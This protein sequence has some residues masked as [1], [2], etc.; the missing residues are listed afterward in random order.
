VPTQDSP[1]TV[2]G[3]ILGTMQYM[4]PE[5]IEGHEADGRTD[6][7]AFGAVVYEMATGTKAFEG[8]SQASLIGAILKD[9]PRPIS[10]LQPMS[11]PALDRVIR[12][13]LAKDPDAR[14]QSA[15]DLRDELQWTVEARSQ[16]A[17]PTPKTSSPQQTN[18]RRAMPWVAGMLL[19]GAV[20]GLDVWSLTTEE[21]TN[22][23]L[24]SRFVI[25]PP[26][27]APLTQ[28][29]GRNVMISPDGRRIVYVGEDAKRGRLL[30]VRD[31][32]ALEGRAVPGTERA[33]DP[34]FSPDGAWIGFERG[35]ALM[36]VAASG[37]PPLEIVDAGAQILGS[38]WGVDD[39]VIFARDD[40]LYRVSAGGGGSVE[41]L[42]PEAEA[43]QSQVYMAPY[44][45]PGGKAVVFYLRNGADWASDRLG[46]LSLETGEQRILIG[47]GGPLYASSGHLVFVRGTTLMAAPFDLERLEV[48]GNPVALLEGI[49]RTG[50]STAQY[51]LSENGT[52]VYR[53]GTGAAGGRTLAWARRNGGEE[54]LAMEPRDYFYSRVSPDGGRVA[55]YA[56]FD[57]WIYDLARGTTTRLTFD[58]AVDVEPLWT[59][60]G[61]RV[62]FA[63]N[64]SGTYDLYW[65]RA[66]G[67]GPEE[68]L[69]MGTQHEFPGS[70]AAGGR[71]LVFMECRTSNG[72]PCDLSVLSLEGERT[73]KVLLQ[74]E[75]DESLPTVSPDGRW[76]AY[77]SNESGSSEI[78]VR[79]LPNVQ[80]GRWQVSSGGGTDPL[81]GP[82]G[83]ELFYRTATSLMVVPVQTGATPMFGNAATLF[84]LGRYFAG[85]GRD[86]D[87]APKG[88]RFILTAPV[89]PKGGAADQIVVVENFFEELKRLVPPN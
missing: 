39:T 37:G 88:D 7:F 44:V 40:G 24:I 77:Q 9:D 75:F 38:T 78:Y 76:L 42:T 29:G 6:I 16:V 28:L 46:V 2:P 36:K 45:L 50:A 82:K 59:P 58:P 80:G 3:T 20:I 83:D 70:W 19:S 65:R 49:T 17:V 51:W 73:A 12:K 55:V 1:I 86:Y 26:E 63:S 23:P 60:D 33:T 85:A 32:D 5:Q 47:G 10:S 22:R 35:T 11:P 41:R 69:T 18:W 15:R 31:I 64:R 61:E 34:F 27:S 68:R 54:A 43:G 4:A 79:P 52:L 89:A 25:T 8:N 56:A 57:I 14:W 13:C 87:I 30:F 48:T 62:V 81:W 21:P 67:T 74:T 72:G 53:P 71:D 66:D 84:N